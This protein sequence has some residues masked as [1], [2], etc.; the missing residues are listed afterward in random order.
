VDKGNGRIIGGCGY[1]PYR[2]KE[3]IQDIDKGIKEY[4]FKF[5]YLH[6]ASFNFNVGD[7]KWYP[8]YMKALEYGVPVGM[9]TGLSAEWLPS[10][11]GN[12]MYIEEAAF[13]FPDVIFI[14]GHTG[15]PWVSE[16]MHLIEKFANVYGD[17]ASYPP[18]AMPDKARIVDFIGRR[19]RGKVMFGSNGLGLKRCKDQFMEFPLSEEVQ[20]EVLRGTTIKVFKL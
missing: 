16:W 13:D 12:P 3:S 18:R 19:G 9:Q 5:I 10:E 11:S 14:L 4:G 15:Y 1:N 6:P 7:R 8:A 20:E 17:I 2:I